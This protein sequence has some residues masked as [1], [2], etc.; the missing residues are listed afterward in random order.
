MLVPGEIRRDL[1]D[2]GIGFFLHI[3][4]P[5]H[6]IFRLLP[7]DRELLRGMLAADLVGFHVR[8]YAWNFLDCVERSLGARVNHKDGLVEYGDHTTRVGAFPIGID[9]GLFESL[10]LEAPT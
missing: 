5:P 8:S 1:P 4:F 10:A 6:D 2:T 7:W 3:P 9:F